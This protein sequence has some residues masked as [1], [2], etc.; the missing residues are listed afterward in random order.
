MGKTTSDKIAETALALFEK[1]GPEAV[2]MRAVAQKAG[3]TPMA[4]YHHF[5]NRE[6]LL[7]A[8]TEGEFEHVLHYI[9]TRRSQL[10][11]KARPSDL[12]LAMMHG[13]IDYAMRHPRLFDYCFSK[14]RPDA[15]RFPDDFKGRLSPTMNPL[16]DGIQAVM[17]AGWLARDDAWEVA[18][19]LTALIHGYLVLYRGGRFNFTEDE[20]RA[21]CERSMNRMF[22]G[23][24]TRNPVQGRAHSNRG[25]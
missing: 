7:H 16:A 8:V 17:D 24:L 1:H 11:A 25:R 15:R 4:I 22:S 2:T 23:L 14:E 18:M 13:Q 3:I 12:L 21:F 20:F 6:A 9:Q 10:P 19:Q 5:P